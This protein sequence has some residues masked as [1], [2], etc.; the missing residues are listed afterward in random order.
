[1]GVDGGVTS[2]TSQVLV[3]T[4]RDVEMGLG[5][6]VLLCQ[7]KIDH[8]DLVATLADAHEEVVWLDVTVDEG[9][10]VDVLNAGDELVGKKQDRLEREL[11]VAEVEEILQR[12]AEQVQDHGI[13]VA[14]GTKPADEGDAD[15]TG[16]GLVDASF[17]L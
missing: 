13:V 3:L 5:V 6:T 7:T 11:A 16:E 14:L 10:G 2:G 8:V 1:M 17:I 9:L 15:T 12:R 4:V